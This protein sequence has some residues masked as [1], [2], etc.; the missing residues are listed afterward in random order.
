MPSLIDMQHNIPY[1]T[2]SSIALF[3]WFTKYLLL[4]PVINSCLYMDKYTIY[5]E[6]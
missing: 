1:S 3:V 5:S 2:I 6:Q 4:F